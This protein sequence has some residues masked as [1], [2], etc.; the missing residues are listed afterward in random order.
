MYEVPVRQNP[1]PA[2]ANKVPGDRLR[3]G[4]VC[5]FV[6]EGWES[7]D[8]AADMLLDEFQRDLHHRVDAVRIRPSMRRRATRIIGGPTYSPAASRLER[9]LFNVDR[10]ANRFWDYPRFL[11]SRQGACDVFHVVD[12]S[13]AQLVHMLPAERTVVTC[14]D[15]EAFRF[16][17][18]ARQRAK[19]S[20]HRMMAERMLSGFRRAAHV[21]CVSEAVREEVIAYQLIPSDR[22]SVI[23]N[24][25]HPACTPDPQ[26][27]A[28]Q[29]A[30]GLLGPASRDVPELLH[31]GS[32]IPR[33]RIDVL[34]QVFKQVRERIPRARLVRAGGAFTP[35]QLHLAEQ[36]GVADSVRV[37]PR[38]DRE[39]LAA[40]YRRAAL[41]LQPS[42]GEGFGLPVAEAMA[43]GAPVVA[44]DLPVLHEVAGHAAT[45]CP[46]A[47]VP[48]WADAVLDLLWERQHNPDAWSARQTESIR[49][50]RRFSWRENA[51]CMLAVYQRLAQAS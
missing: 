16:V 10:L 38:M 13:Y 23:P 11:G 42:E 44:S 8:L 12:H 48:V 51:L 31:V 1:A 33:K 25:V 43:C 46:V 41:V 35:A 9:T 50:A 37:L 26:V 21:V 15:L 14:H 39:T 18:D 34:L 2:T 32:T 27:A 24:G 30:E 36:L 20:I 40:V 6:E 49:T 28:E 3:V 47:N 4:I 29:R 5:D 45:F 17:V 7:M 22:L 19:S